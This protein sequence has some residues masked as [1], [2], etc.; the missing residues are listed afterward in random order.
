MDN[1]GRLVQKILQHHYIIKHTS[2][3]VFWQLLYFYLEIFEDGKILQRIRH[4]FTC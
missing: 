4:Y 3:Q 2:K 1:I